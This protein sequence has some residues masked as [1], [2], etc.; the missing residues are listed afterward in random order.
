VRGTGGREQGSKRGVIRKG[1]EGGGGGGRQREM[2]GGVWR[3]SGGRV[4]RER[5]VGE[6]K[7]CRKKS[8]L[9]RTPSD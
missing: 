4:W 2:R 5:M 7:K 3:G 9:G 6:R 8:D 1:G